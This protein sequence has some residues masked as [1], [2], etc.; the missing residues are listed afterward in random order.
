VNFQWPLALIALLVVPLVVA[1]YVARHRRRDREIARFA[2]PA[3]LPNLVSSS[4]GWRR[5]VPLAVLLAALTAMLVGIARPQTTVS[6]PRKAAT[7]VVAL[8]VSRSMQSKDVSPTRLEAAR[9]AATA[10][11][12][13]VPSTYSVAVVVFAERPSVVVP[14]T[15]DRTL[16]ERGLRAARRGEG[17]ALGSAI[18]L[19]LTVGRA[20]TVDGV[21]PPASVLLIS[22]GA[23]T[24]GGPLPKAAAQRAK[25]LQIPVST[26][27]IGTPEG[28]VER[29]LTGG[30]KEITRVPP[31]P[32]TMR[33]IAETS[34]GE[35]MQTLNDARV[36]NV[37]KKLGTRIGHRRQQR[38]ITDWFAAGAAGLVLAGAALSV[39]W[40]RRV[41]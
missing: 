30:F 19:A 32:D 41:A 37:Y 2:T 18:Q 35:F 27:V 8:D 7:V 24:S 28:T 15:T 12:R 1:I 17:T 26:V 33:T 22:D 13:R 10:F 4:P 11:V 39:L 16:V 20:R 21:R 38:E 36:D 31:D 3:L 23:Q 9:A 25:A 5:H 40:F 6:V 34:G 29:T 14:P